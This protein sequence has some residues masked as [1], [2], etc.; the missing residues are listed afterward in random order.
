MSSSRA[1]NLY[2]LLEV[3]IRLS[4][5]PK[6]DPEFLDKEWIDAFFFFIIFF[7]FV[8]KSLL[9]KKELLHFEIFF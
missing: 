6:R 7:Q 1:D 4:E 5:S 8:E 2:R 9:L 3:S